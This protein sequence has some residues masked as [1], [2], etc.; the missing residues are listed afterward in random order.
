[1]FTPLLNLY[2]I[3]AMVILIGIIQRLAKLL[4]HNPS[5]K[6]TRFYSGLLQVIAKTVWVLGIIGLLV[7]T[8]HPIAFL[9]ILL[10]VGSIVTAN[11]SRV[12]EERFAVNR[13]FE[14]AIAQQISFARVFEELSRYSH[15]RL[16]NQTSRFAK[17]L[18]DGCSLQESIR[19]SRLPVDS[20]M[21]SLI[22]VR[23]ANLGASS[24]THETGLAGRKV[25]EYSSERYSAEL[26]SQVTH[27]F[28]YLATL[29]AG[30]WALGQFS[31]GIVLP[32]LKLIFDELELAP[33][34]T[35]LVGTGTITDV[36][37]YVSNVLMVGFLTWLGL[38]MCIR[39]VPGVFIRCIPWFGSTWFE[40]Q[41]CLVIRSLATGS[42]GGVADRDI[43]LSAADTT[44]IRWVAKKC[45][46]TAHLL[47]QGVALQD[48]LIRTGLLRRKDGV[49]LEAAQKNGSLSLAYESLASSVKRRLMYRWRL[50]IAWFVPLIVSLMGVYVLA[51]TAMLF[52]YLYSIVNAL[53]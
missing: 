29:V 32:Q 22:G 48:A 30:C 3:V 21:I 10:F 15:E 13:C 14:L 5:R 53:A 12:R 8:P 25:N 23:Q 2:V 52:Q 46:K 18:R 31:R 11:L 24:P 35:S 42:A 34:F 6:R 4:R 27:H 37:V 33:P 17:K 16:S 7:S 28:I 36:L 51:H 44:S 9:L 45:R 43:L 49:R 41:S 40:N 47:D 1:M 20:G 39:W 50:R 38:A 26:E 19:S